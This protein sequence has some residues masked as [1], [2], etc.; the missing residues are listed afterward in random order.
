MEYSKFTFKTALQLAAPHTWSP[1]V[2]PVLLA[3][4]CTLAQGFD[5]SPL[6]VVV[7]L[8]ISVSMQA[9][10]NT[11][12]DYFDF[13]K[14]VDSV[15]DN[16]EVDDAALLYSNVRPASA[17]R[18]AVCLLVAAFLLGIYVIWVAGWPPLV[19]AVIGAAAVFA[20]SAGKTPV[21]YLPIGEAVSGIVMG[22]LITAA[23]YYSLTLSLGWEVFVWSAPLALQTGLI[24]MA[25]NTCDIEKDV[26]AGRKT[27]PVLLGRS[28]A[29]AVYR[30]IAVICCVADIAIVAAWFGS[31]AIGLPF[32]ALIALPML[33]NFW[34]CPFNQP[35]RVMAMSLATGFNAQLGCMYCACILLSAAIG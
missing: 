4:S 16:L 15:E 2:L 7:L 14:G 34:K 27:L 25:N 31:G 35:S 6:L 9:S 28:K 18:F 5:A 24:M 29:V 30:C 33:I 23:S 10:V 17:L 8:A 1:S 22:C 26:E 12:N 3:L 20:Y 19:F 21:S 13:V 11:L 32:L